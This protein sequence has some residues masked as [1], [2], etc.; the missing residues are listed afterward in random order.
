MF[1]DCNIDSII[2][3]LC[4]KRDEGYKTVELIDDARTYGWYCW[5]PKIS[6]IT[7]SLEPTVLGIDVR[8]K[9]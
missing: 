9:Q 7:N 4:K 1:V 8:S 5:D 6:F 3:F 2:D